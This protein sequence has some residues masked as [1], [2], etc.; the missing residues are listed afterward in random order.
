MIFDFFSR[1]KDGRTNEFVIPAS[2]LPCF[3]AD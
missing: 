2:I 1:K 3:T